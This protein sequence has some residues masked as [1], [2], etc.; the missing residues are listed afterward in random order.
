MSPSQQN[1]LK[2]IRDD[3]ANWQSRSREDVIRDI[4]GLQSMVRAG[5]LGGSTMPEDAHPG[6][7]RDSAKN[8]HY[9]TLP[10]ALNYQRDSYALWRAATATYLDEQTS[11]VFDPVSV[12]NLS[13]DDLRD[14]LLKHKLAL[15]QNRHPAIWK[16][17]SD[18]IVRLF[19]GDIR[20]LFTRTAGRVGA[21][22]TMLQEDEKPS[23][24]YLSGNKICHYWLYVMEQYTDVRLN[25]RQLI[26]VAPDTHVIKA[27]CR[28]GLISPSLAQSPKAQEQAKAAWQSVLSGTEIQP[29]DVHTR[30][31]LWSRAGFPR[32]APSS[33]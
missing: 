20:N 3:D 1:L 16:K 32:I 11:S 10:M 6:I 19:D 17:I 2:D 12:L 33:D 9:F 29:I 4:A 7:A 5:V 30:L 25:D 27:T 26:S 24:P 18:A 13:D 28:L 23:F 21:I 22:L 31:W 15:Q 8:Y 14:M